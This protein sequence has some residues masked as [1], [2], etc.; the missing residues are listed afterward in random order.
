MLEFFRKFSS[1]RTV[2]K[3]ISEITVVSGTVRS[4]QYGILMSHYILISLSAGGTLNSWVPLSNDDVT[5]G[6]LSWKLQ[7]FNLSHKYKGLILVVG[8]HAH[9][10]EAEKV[11]DQH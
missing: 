6:C 4:V 8:Y 10:R 5:R 1:L 7:I 9:I 2:F 11:Q 3:K